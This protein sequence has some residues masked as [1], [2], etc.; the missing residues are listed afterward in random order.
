VSLSRS[1]G[2][3]LGGF[4]AATHGRPVIAVGYG[5]PPD[6]LG[7]DWRGRVPHRMIRA[8][9]LSGYEWFD[10]GYFWPQPDDE[11]AFAL[12]REFAA[13]PAPFRAEVEA[14]SIRIREEFGAD[15]VTRRLLAALDQV[16]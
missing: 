15:A 13:N 16:G 8:E 12:M 5:G 1:E 14:T 6:Y 11:A 3:G 9:N 2:F 7:A 4:D 10:D